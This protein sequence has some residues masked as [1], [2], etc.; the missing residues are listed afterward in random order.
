M[1]QTPSQTRR[2]LGGW[3]MANSEWFRSVSLF[4]LETPYQR[5]DHPSDLV[6]LFG[7]LPERNLADQPTR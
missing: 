6:A 3:R 5:P 7:H 1:V 2:W 4:L